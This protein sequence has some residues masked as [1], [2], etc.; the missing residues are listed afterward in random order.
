MGC[1]RV[2]TRFYTRCLERTNLV[3]PSAQCR[4][5]DGR[6]K[7]L[8]QKPVPH[9]RNVKRL[10]SLATANGM[11]LD[12]EVFRIKGSQLRILAAWLDLLQDSRTRPALQ[13]GNPPFFRGLG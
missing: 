9:R 5:C 12:G 3:E 2:G 4:I 10:A 13:M 8:P 1:G 7:P 11:Y 6:H